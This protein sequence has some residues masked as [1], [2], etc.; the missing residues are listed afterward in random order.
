MDDANYDFKHTNHGFINV[1]RRK[2]GLSDIPDDPTNKSDLFYV[3]VENLLNTKAKS[4][5]KIDD[6]YKT[7][8]SKDIFFDYFRGEFQ[9]KA[10]LK[11]EN[12]E[13]LDH[14][15]DAWKVGK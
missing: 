8:F 12:E 9:L 11:M 1:T 3:E 2:I 15:F 5:Q 6:S 4:V 10:N 7:R 13:L 14:R